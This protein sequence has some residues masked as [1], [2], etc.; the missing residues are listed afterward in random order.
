[1]QENKLNVSQVLEQVYIALNE[2]GYNPINQIV[3]YI[4][5]GDPTYITSHKNARSLI[6]KVERDEILEELMGVYIDTKLK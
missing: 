2:K 4:M 5:S 3:G 6:M 1:M